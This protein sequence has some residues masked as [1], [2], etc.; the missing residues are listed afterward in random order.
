MTTSDNGI[1]RISKAGAFYIPQYDIYTT[2]FIMERPGLSVQFDL[3][4]DKMKTLLHILKLDFDDGKYIHDK[5][6]GEY[7]HIIFSNTGI[8]ETVGD[9]FAEQHINIR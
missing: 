6:V 3:D 5:L 4:T 7:L 9:P 1:Y 8:V 2:H